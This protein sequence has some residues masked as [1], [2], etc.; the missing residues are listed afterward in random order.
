MWETI[1]NW[2]AIDIGSMVPPSKEICIFNN[3]SIQIMRLN[4]LTKD[5]TILCYSNSIF[6]SRAYDVTRVPIKEHL[7]FRHV[8][9]SEGDLLDIF[10]VYLKILWLFKVIH[11]FNCIL[12]SL[13]ICFFNFSMITLY[14]L[15][16]IV[17]DTLLT[18]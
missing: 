9:A 16:I 2:Q 12:W 3:I 1:I 10:G 7:P 4:L 14:E 13:Y 6:E 18:Y 15:V 17:N 8:L 11:S 5:S